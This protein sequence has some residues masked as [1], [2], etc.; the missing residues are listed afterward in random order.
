[1]VAQTPENLIG[2]PMKGKRGS[3]FLRYKRLEDDRSS[4]RS[5]YIEITDYLLPRRGR[6]LI[7]SQNSKGRK[8][9]SKI[10]DNT[11]GQALRTLSAGLMSG[12]TSPARPW[13]RL[14]TAQQEL[15]DRPGVKDW[16]GQAERIVRQILARSNFYNSASTIYTELGAF[17]TAALYRRRHPTDIVSFRPFTAGE[18]VI[19][20]NEYGQVD[21]LGREFTMSVAQ[22]VEQFVIDKTTGQE[23]WS[24]VSKAVKG[25]WDR[26]AYDERVEIIHL[27]QPR[28]AEDRD[29][30]KRDGK[31]KP[32]MDVY[33]EKGSD[34]DVVL[35]ESGYDRFPAYCPRWDVLGGDVYGVSPAMEQLGDIK[36]L[37]HEQK[38]KAQAIDKMVN[39]PMVAS[40]S[41]KGKPS[42]V[43]PGGTTYVDAMQGGAG[44]APAYTV[45]PRINEMMMDIQEVQN[46]IQRG[47]Y[48]DLFAMM[49]NSDRRQ[50]TA[51][52]VAERHEEKLALLG[53]V[54]QRLNTEF[55][56]PMVN[57]VFL[58]ALDAGMLPP[59]PPEL[60]GQSI[61]I[62]YVSLLAQ[63][64]EAVAASSIERA[65]S[66]AGN[67]V[68]VFPEITD[69]L[70]AD[71]AIRQYSETLGISP[72]VIRESDQVAA[73]RQQRADAMQAQADME[74]AMQ[75]TQMAATGAQA[76][77]VLS[78]ADTQNPNALTE[79]LRGGQG[80]GRLTV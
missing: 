4:W 1:M 34:K 42:T 49:I 3:V 9:S 17:G 55:L 73:L 56:D 70:D 12:M 71:M 18:Y 6:Y 76:A 32:F 66:F 25:L 47:F 8:R 50:M 11:A 58:F 28:R 14:M 35:F 26:K 38:R 30:T 13:F 15:M 7:E 31:N 52:E 62:K 57:D 29:L 37:Q 61:D 16:L 45:Q 74:S 22:V 5:H 44:F 48:A 27:I 19:A 36:Q 65:F 63:A 21:T 39:P 10:V 72:E 69:N 40:T 41:L 43:L 68:A 75:Q 46:R 24:S 77:K 54:L 59:P 20:E 64:Q 33:I 51:T 23:D 78:E 60:E 2:S 80:A 67:L 53:P 79:L